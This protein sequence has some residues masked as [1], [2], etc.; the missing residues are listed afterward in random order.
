MAKTIAIKVDLQGTEAQQKKLAKL[1][2]E[3]KKLT[4]RRTELNKALKK[5]TISLDQYGK[6]IAKINT[7]LKANRREMLVA[8][9]NILGLDSFTKKLGKSF[10][11]LGTSISG[12]FIG[13][14]AVQKFF[15][16]ISDGITDRDWETI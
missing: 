1:E 15:Q 12:A 10:S 4:T 8:R 7:K 16:V 6:E 11:K 9:E 14:F 3:V 5:G 13:L 2:A